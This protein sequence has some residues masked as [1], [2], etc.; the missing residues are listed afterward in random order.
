MK[1][2]PTILLRKNFLLATVLAAYPLLLKAGAPSTLEADFKNPP[3][4][5]K[6]YVWWHWMGPNFSKEGITK[7]LEAMKA[8]GIGGAT[9]FNI[10]SAVQES[11]Q[12]TLNNPWPNQTYRSPAYWDAVKH[13]AA[14][15]VRLGLEVGLHNTVGY[16]TTGGPW[17]PQDKAMQR[18]VWTEEKVS[19]GR[20]VDTVLQQPAAPAYRG[21]GGGISAPIT[22]YRDVAV[23][24][25]PAGG[26]PEL[27]DVV[28]LSAKL[29]P[30]GRLV[31]ENAP[32]GDWIVYRF[33]HAPTGATPHPLPDDQIGKALEA[34]KMSLEASRYHWD[35]VIDPLRKSLGPL[36][37]KGL[38]FFLIDSYEA[39]YQNWTP[40]FRAEFQK[41]KG[42]DPVPWLATIGKPITND[43]DGKARRVIGSEDMTARFEWDYRDVIETLYY[44]NGW[45]PAVEKI[46][47][48]GCTLQFEPYGGPFN[49]VEGAALADL[50][51][52]EFWTGRS[53]GINAAI[54]AAARAAGRTVVGAEAFT[55]PPKFS[56]WSE[57]PAFLKPSGD[58]TYASGVNRMVLHH[59][60]HQPFDDRYQPGM[61][62]GWWGTHFSR[63][64]TWF[65]PGKAFFQYLGRVQ[66][67]LQRGEAPADYVSV[68][69][70]QGEGDVIPWRVLRSGVDVRDGKIAL[71]SGR[72]YPFLSI[73]N[74]GVLLP[75][76]VKRI[77][78]LLAKGAVIVASKPDR[79]PSLAGYPACDAEVKSLADKIWGDGKSP[80]LPVGPGKLYATGDLNAAIRD[81]KITPAAQV[82]TAGAPGIRI[83]H[84]RDGKTDLF[85][86]T[87]PKEAPQAFT[88]SFRIDGRRPE[89]WNAETG[90]I[91]WAPVWRQEDG[92]TE[93]DLRLGGIKSIFVVFR[94]GPLPPDHAVSASIGA[95]GGKAEWTMTGLPAG[96]VRIDSAVPLTG[97]VVFASG[98]KEPIQ[99]NPPAQRQIATPWDVT[100]QSAVEE[101]RK[102]QLPALGSLAENSDPAVK[103]FSGTATYRTTL[104][105]TD[106]EI[107][108]GKAPLILK[109]GDVANLARVT[110]NGK[111]LGVRW[112]PPFEFDLSSAAKSGSN[113]LEIA[114]T[115]TWHNRLV[116]DEQFPADFEWG[117]DRGADKGRAI[118][119]Y[120]DWFIKKQPRPE[121]GRKCFVVWYYHRKE[122]PL[123]PSGLIGPVTLAPEASQTVGK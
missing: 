105:L 69:S 113:Q 17:I 20:T 109:L 90:E 121:K 24:A 63:F 98:R 65:E 40:G 15:A 32:A 12:P 47:Q 92:R 7:D 104:T 83:P 107:G 29:K 61:G 81:F 60:V 111:D 27:K 89:L 48:A 5:V 55:G 99:L 68:G 78:E 76:D 30:D 54:P 36:L 62:M 18:L 85:F 64:Q 31:W 80:V 79:S 6:P 72:T 23:L 21:W 53:G 86:V 74:S 97:E 19:G 1:F 82:T 91:V 108:G 11:Q 22:F 102:I 9:I 101:A 115:N 103:Y 66:A 34:D 112:H 75:A 122:T 38:T 26:T 42:Y 25:V 3:T 87:N 8:A 49:T 57:T 45:L 123:L 37:G 46:H 73:P 28:D 116:G 88:V 58:G 77:S 43:K 39:G 41:R 110:L 119:A 96:G 4:K 51:M 70:P 114:V 117:T 44:E 52:G 93:V 95:G 67:M 118:K 35:Q 59:W 94:D 33:G 84:R 106:A 14:E 16:S 71:P 50:P 10:T 100:L 2:S 56:D 13:A 120:P